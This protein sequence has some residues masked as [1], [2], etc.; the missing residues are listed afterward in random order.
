MAEQTI[1]LSAG[2]FTVDLVVEPSPKMQAII[3]ELGYRV[4]AQ[5][6][7]NVWEKRVGW[8][9]ADKRPEG[10]KRGNIPFSLES[11]EELKKEIDLLYETEKDDKGNEVRIES[12]ILDVQNLRQFVPKTNVPKFV[13]QK[14]MVMAYL[15]EP[16]GT[17]P[18][19]TKD[20]LE[21]SVE[22]LCAATGIDVPTD[23]WQEDAVF[24]GA[25]K[26]WQAELQAK[27]IAAATGGL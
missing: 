8:K 10:W 12:G 13:E 4:F 1:E 15:F 14:A 27:A 25:I 17:T 21:R 16:D 24:L 7:V 3:N 18:K 5:N 2:N 20:G 22:T 11:A 6:A 19:K 26:A 9:G 23:P